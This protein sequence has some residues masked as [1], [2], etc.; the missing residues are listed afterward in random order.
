MADGAINKMDKLT[1][2][3]WS[4]W[5]KV[6]YAILKK[7]KVWDIVTG[8]R[9]ALTGADASDTATIEFV[10]KQEK[11]C[12]WLVPTISPKLSY[13]IPNEPD[14]PAVIWK[15]LVEHFESKSA[16]NVFHL[17]NQLAQLKLIDTEDPV[18][19]IRQ[20]VELYEQLSQLGKKVEDDDQCMATL[21]L[22]PKLYLPLVTSL[23]TQLAQGALKMKQ[24]SDFL[25]N[26]RKTSKGSAAQ[27]ERAYAASAAGR[28]RSKSRGRGRGGQRGR[29]NYGNGRDGAQGG[30]SG[31][32]CF[33]CG[34]V[35]HMVIDCPS[36]DE[37]HAKWSNYAAHSTFLASAL[38]CESAYSKRV[39]M[40]SG[41]TSHMTYNKDWLTDFKDV[42]PPE[43]VVLGDGHRVF[44]HGIGTLAVTLQFDDDMNHTADMRNCLFVPDLSCS[45]F[46]VKSATAD[47]TKM[48]TF[49]RNGAKI[50]DLENRLLGVGSLKDGVYTLNCTVQ[51]PRGSQPVGLAEGESATVSSTNTCLA[52]G[53]SADTWHCRF[54]HLGE[55][56]MTKLMNS[57]LV[58]GMDVSTKT[59]TFCEPCVQGKA[60]QQPYPKQSNNRSD[61]IMDLIHA[62][63]CGPLKPLSLGGKG[64]F[65][66]FTDDYSRFVWVRFIRYK[67]EVFQKFRDLVKELEKGTGRK[68]KALRSDRGGEFLS[69]E[70]QQYMKRRGIRHQ[71]TTA[72]S[73]Q[74]NGVAERMNR[75]LTEKART[76]IA[77]ANI[78]KTFWAEAIA[79]AAYVRNRS[80]TSSLRNMT[81]FEAWWGHKPS[82]KHLRTF[83]CTAYAH[84]SKGKRQKLASKTEQCIFLGYSTCSKAYRVYNIARKMMLVRRNVT[85][86]ESALGREGELQSE[87]PMETIELELGDD[88]VVDDAEE[89]L[90]EGTDSESS[91]ASGATD[92]EGDA[93]V[94]R[95]TSRANAGVPPV[96]YSDARLHAHVLAADVQVQDPR[97]WQEAMKSQ[98][99][100]KWRQAAQTEYK[101]LMDHGTWELVQLPPDKKLVGSRWVFKAKHD[102]TGAVER[103][104]ALFVAQGFTQVFGEDYNQTFSPVV[105][106]ESVR[107][108]ISLAVQYGMVIHQMDVETA[109]LNG[110]LK[111]D[112]YMKQP[113]GFVSPGQHNLVCKLKRSLYGLKQSPRCWNEVLHEQLIDMQFV[114]SAAD[115]CLYIGKM[116]GSLVFVAIYV[117]DIIIA[118]EKSPVVQKTKELFAKKFKVKDMGKLH[119]FLGVGIHQSDGTLWLGQEK[120]A[121]NILTK[122][123]METC[124]AVSTPMETTAHPA[125]TTGDSTPFDAKLY[126]S[127]IGSL[128]YLANVTR[129]DIAQAVHK[130]A[131]FS[132]QPTVEHWKLVKRILRYVQG[133]KGIGLLYTTDQDSSLV[134]YSDADYAGDVN[135]RKSTS[136]FVFLKNGAAISWRSKK[137]SVVAQSTA[138]AEYVALFYAAQQCVWFREMLVSLKQEQPDTMI[139]YEDS[140]S[141]IQIYQNAM[142]HPK[143][144]HIGVKYHFTREKVLD[145]VIKLEYCNT[146][147]MVADILTKP[148]ARDRF[149]LLRAKMG[150]HTQPQN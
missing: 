29:G 14:D 99:A 18:P 4:Y 3:N 104:K 31:R 113:E 123:K 41:A 126:Q 76:M 111:E 137:Q 86:N 34:G 43:V 97:S 148:L 19:W 133:T 11:A 145:G 71:L 150:L 44:A 13:L 107:T 61:H 93:V 40:D 23:T 42:N 37:S 136:G 141:A 90:P 115:Q 138:E 122:F 118:S 100:D 79:N 39:I 124:S 64:Y 134:V 106:W 47:G 1:D 81:P 52:A 17:Q 8:T 67:S 5:R 74:Q 114:Q 72:D 87:R 91:D 85:F 59:L 140:Q 82:V 119:Y 95:R 50:T 63:V 83:G 49:G 25:E 6:M 66:T 62:D 98:Q 2:D 45:L 102:S 70:F 36:P 121:E 65:V 108:I 101:S 22:L 88:V 144:K 92:T 51:A 105:R 112:I 68:L 130:M 33:R 60:H 78:P 9:I 16:F 128:L 24:L 57:D 96:R 21:I 77:A 54:G 35:G 32:K 139:I 75:T 120:Y 46:S 30:S 38:L 12:G 142:H 117:D 80:P 89:D 143:T 26:Y 73:P 20:R 48:V 94:L 147:D 146:V 149:E 58:N 27:E 28:G 129:P 69:N 84:V 125:K 15:N 135:D 131:Q 109:F 110:W 56:N 7:E 55:Q 127:A 10:A 116:N 103:Y 132:A 53:V